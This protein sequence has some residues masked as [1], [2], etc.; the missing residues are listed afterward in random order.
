[1]AEDFSAK[2]NFGDLPYWRTGDPDGLGH[3]LRE[4][5]GKCGRAS[6]LLPDES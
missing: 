2:W 4:S 1:M 3:N 6:W 5:H